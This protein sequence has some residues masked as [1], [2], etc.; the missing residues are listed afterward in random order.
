MMAKAAAS[1]DLLSGGRFELGLGA[2]AFWDAIAAYGG[3]RRSPGEAL[4]ALAEAIDVIRLVWSGDRGVRFEGEHYRLGGPHSG[5]VPAHPIGIWLGVYGPRA[6]AITGRLA[7]GWVP[8][9]RP[10]GPPLA[11][12]VD[13]LDQSAADA[14]RHPGDIRRILNIGGTITDGPSSGILHGPAAQWVDELSAF[15]IDL[16]FDTFITSGDD[17]DHLRRFAVEVVPGVRAGVAAARRN[18][19]RTLAAVSGRRGAGVGAGRCAGCGSPR[20][21]G[22]S[23]GSRRP[24]ATRR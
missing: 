21:R 7:D 13:R 23:A 22:P 14:G 9:L 5:P 17:H 11:D 12:M 6:I 8:S 20:S 18:R 16:G 10:D 19:L 3:E 2:G 1:I 4:G 15:A 24:S